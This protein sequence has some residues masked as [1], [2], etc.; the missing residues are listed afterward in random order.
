MMKDKFNVVKGLEI[1]KDAADYAKNQFGVDVK[2][3]DFMNGFDQQKYD[4]V[5][6]W[7]VIEHLYSPQKNI[8]KKYPRI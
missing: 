7:D 3:T 8:Y 2:D 6:M 5:C 1:F 4:L